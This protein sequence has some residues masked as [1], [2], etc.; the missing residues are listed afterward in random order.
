MK[1]Y[2]VVDDDGSES[3]DDSDDYDYD[4]VEYDE[5]MSMIF[6]IFLCHSFIYL[7]F[8]LSQAQ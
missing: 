5:L 3:D 8:R 7:F 1:I 4:N 2:D 6:I